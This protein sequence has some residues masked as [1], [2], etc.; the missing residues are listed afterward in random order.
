MSRIPVPTHSHSARPHSPATI[1]FQFP[2]SPELP[3][4]PAPAQY[5][6]NVSL[7]KANN[8]TN[9]TSMSSVSGYQNN[10]LSV[11]DTRKKQ[12]KRDEVVHKSFNLSAVPIPDT[13][14]PD[15]LFARKSNQSSHASVP[16]HTTKLVSAQSGVL[17]KL[18]L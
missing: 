4:S 6:L 5:H 1:P 18:P 11:S 2:S 14:L 16:S 10:S 12:S 13:A 3:G 17:A 9:T 7:S 8:L 15:R